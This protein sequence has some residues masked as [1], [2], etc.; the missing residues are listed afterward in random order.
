VSSVLCGFYGEGNLGDEA[1]LAGLL[2][3]LTGI[4]ALR[5]AVVFT[6]DPEQTRLVHGVAGIHRRG[7]RYALARA[8]AVL[9]HRALILGGG[10]LLR[11]ALEY[12]VAE[13]WLSYLRVARRLGARTMLLG[14]SVGEIWRPQTR[15]LM[16][17]EL[18]RVDLL[19]VRDSA[20][21]RALQSLGLEREILVAPDNALLGRKLEVRPRTLRA[22]PLI[23]LSVRHIVRRGRAVTASDFERARKALALFVDLLTKKID[24][25]FVLLPFRSSIRGGASDDDDL[26]ACKDLGPMFG[27]AHGLT[28]AG[29]FR[30]PTEAEVVTRKLDLLIGMR[31][32]SLVLAA[33]AGVPVI[34]LEYD[35]KVREFMKEIGQLDFSFALR[36][37]DPE[38]VAESALRIL[39]DWPSMRLNVA[40]GVE[41]YR[42]SEERL[43]NAMVNFA[44]E[45]PKRG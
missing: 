23:G 5:P 16:L 19:A 29:P 41:R 32:H 21:Q 14:V 36:D 4:P 42:D 45:R 2:R 7:R 10:D 44:E 28:I 34:A 43:L 22:S 12:S 9:R 39:G 1:M 38:K 37:L 3:F 11:D 17:S 15:A 35:R 26:R 24:A 18:K 6:A 25:R 40:R 30:T 8:M 31:L 13:R 33:A 20:S 27:S